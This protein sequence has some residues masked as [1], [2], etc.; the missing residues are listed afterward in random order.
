[1]IIGSNTIISMVNMIDTEIAIPRSFFFAPAAAPVA[2]AALVPHTD[3][4]EA[5]VMTS[6]LLTILRMRV[7]NHH[8]K[9][10]TIG[11]TTH[12]TPSP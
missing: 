2:I 4:A 6:G 3:V 12:A 8:M 11:V 1:M 7:P 9:R 5:S 10:I